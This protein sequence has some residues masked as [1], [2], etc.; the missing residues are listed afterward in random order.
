MV[1]C[2]YIQHYMVGEGPEQGGAAQ[3]EPGS[4]SSRQRSA[5]H[6]HQAHFGKFKGCITRISI[7]IEGVIYIHTHTH[8]HLA[9]LM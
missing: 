3:A 1:N 4:S 9:S 8:T 7:G 5:A 2:L 6:L